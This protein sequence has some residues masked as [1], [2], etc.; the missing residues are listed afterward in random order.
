MPALPVNLEL[1]TKLSLA[2]AL[3]L[4]RASAGAYERH[5]TAEG[6]DARILDLDCGT[7][8]V[9]AFRGS[10][11]ASDFVVDA[12][13]RR[14]SAGDGIGVHHGFYSTI[15][16]IGGHLIQRAGWGRKL[17]LF[18]TGHSLGGALA[19]L[20]AKI[21]RGAGFFIQGV[22]VFGCPRVGNKRFAETYDCCLGD[23]TYRFVNEED[24]VARV[25]GW[26]SGYRHVGTEIFLPSGQAS[27]LKPQTS[28]G[29]IVDP[30][31]WT[32]GRSDVVGWWRD[33]WV[34]R[35]AGLYDHGVAKYVSRL[36]SITQRAQGPQRND[37]IM[38]GQN[39]GDRIPN[40]QLPTS[41]FELPTSNPEKGVA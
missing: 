41:N 22:Y 26:V 39:H 23:R 19:V 40:A 5:P 13:I 7:A 37:R 9:I 18:I 17:P 32:K 35:V 31:I 10:C 24:V 4:A 29:Y 28:S 20:A 3:A 38:A 2:N 14:S 6:S 25:P 8:R 30:S 21:L 33:F 1:T 34:G 11:E 16:V 15:S 12:E 36:E 27:N